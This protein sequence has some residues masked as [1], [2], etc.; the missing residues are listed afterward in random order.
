MKRTTLARMG[1]YALLA[2]GVA[3]TF[4]APANAAP[5]GGSST[6]SEIQAALQRDLG[7]SPQQAQVRFQQENAAFAKEGTLRATLGADYAASRFD[8][9]SGKLV[10]DVTDASRVA[11]VTSAGAVARVVQHSAAELNAV[12]AKLDQNTASMGE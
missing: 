8:A 6:S 9:K 12:Q 1:G 2:A 5:A 7:L 3:L 11:D 4:A 10:V